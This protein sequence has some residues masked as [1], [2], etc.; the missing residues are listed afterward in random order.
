MTLQD[1]TFN[2]KFK[3]L[4]I[5]T[6]TTLLAL[7]PEDFDALFDMKW[8]KQWN[9]IRNGLDVCTNISDE[10]YYKLPDI[11]FF[12]NGKPYT[13]YRDQYLQKH[14]NYVA[15][16]IVPGGKG[17]TN[18]IMGMGFLEN[19]YSIYDYETKRVG[20]APSKNPNIEGKKTHSALAERKIADVMNST[21]LM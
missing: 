20:L 10:E 11:K 16:K 3:Q 12:I 19:Y 4:N 21:K 7:P 9:C 1:E 5:D 2:P 17:Q 14:D 15:I 13:L 18:W 8:F 6:G